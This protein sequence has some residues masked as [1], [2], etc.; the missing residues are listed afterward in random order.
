[1]RIGNKIV[2][3]SFFYLF[4]A[5]RLINLLINCY[6]YNMNTYYDLC[7]CR[8]LSSVLLSGELPTFPHQLHHLL[9]RQQNSIFNIMKAAK[10]NKKLQDT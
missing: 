3:N 9:D 5:V 6:S 8:E 2:S 7:S 10:H 1:M 4:I